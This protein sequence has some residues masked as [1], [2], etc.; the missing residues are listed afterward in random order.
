MRVEHIGGINRS[1]NVG[2][3]RGVR[4]RVWEGG[5]EGVFPH[6]TR[7][8]RVI[9]PSYGLHRVGKERLPPAKGKKTTRS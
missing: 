8:K 2:K 4:G 9:M 6:A 7:M 1:G 5:A 3:E